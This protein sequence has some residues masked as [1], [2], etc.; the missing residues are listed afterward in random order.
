MRGR[1]GRK[2]A[3][4]FL[5]A[6]CVAAALPG[7][8]LAHSDYVWE[9]A[10]RPYHVLP[11]T[12]ALSVAIEY[13]ALIFIAHAGRRGRTLIIVLAGNALAFG[14]GCAYYIW[15]NSG[16]FPDPSWPPYIVGAVFLCASFV[17]GVLCEDAALK[18]YAG[19]GSGRVIWTLLAANAATAG[20][21]ALAERLIC[22]GHWGA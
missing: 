19:A 15:S 13:A 7:G 10:A 16:E 5:T 14:V 2:A 21:C 20:I 18:K 8:A 17:I 4:T 22:A 11:F 3:V 12:F 9:T 1:S 6:L